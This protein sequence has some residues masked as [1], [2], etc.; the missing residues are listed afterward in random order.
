MIKPHIPEIEISG[1][2]PDHQSLNRLILTT[3]ELNLM[4]SCT[5]LEVINLDLIAL[6]DRSKHERA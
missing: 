5:M 1:I 2:F 6:F 4:L 3:N